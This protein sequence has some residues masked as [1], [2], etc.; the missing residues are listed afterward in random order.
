[1][2][3]LDGVVAAALAAGE[4]I[5]AIYAGPADA[6]AKADGSPVT[7]ADEK[8]EAIITQHLAALAPGVPVVA[9]EAV[10]AGNTPDCGALFFLVDPL[11]GTKEFLSR[12]GEFTV[13][14]G[15]IRN[16][17]PVLGVV[18]APA[19]GLLYAGGAG[20]PARRAEV[21]DHEVTGW[22]DLKVRPAP[23]RLTVIGS[24][25]HGGAET[26]AFVARLPVADFVAAGSSLKFCRLAEGAADLYPRLGRTM[27]WDIAAGHAVLAAAGGAVLTLDGVP[28]AYGKRAQAHD[29]DFANPYFVATAGYDPFT[30]EADNAA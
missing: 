30:L 29:S 4:A 23:A 28:L 12:N 22:V 14:I 13:N 18:Y 16:G 1:M 3:L 8:A 7:L 19:L 17:V 10:A 24:R 26:E 5:L 2:A 21:A 9:E 15:L 20:V 6:A 27:E 25:S 11:D